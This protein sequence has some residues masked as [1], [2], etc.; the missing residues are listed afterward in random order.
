MSMGP[1]LIGQ[2]DADASG[3]RGRREAFASLL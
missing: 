2:A 3:P 1:A